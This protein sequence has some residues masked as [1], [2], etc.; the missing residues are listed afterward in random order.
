MKFKTLLLALS[1]ACLIPAI[2]QAKP[3]GQGPGRKG[4]NPGQMFKKFDTDKSG[5][6]SKTEAADANRLLKQFDNIDAD[7]DGEITK[8]EFGKHHKA[9]AEK[10][11]GARDEHLKEL[12]A[13]GSGTISFEEAENG[14]AKRMVDN[15]DKLDAD[16]DG[17]ISTEE[18]KAVGDK[19]RDRKKG[20]R[21]ESE[22]A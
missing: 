18:L 15:F 14:D 4:P 11:K 12:D 16:G 9:M 13:D 1:A 7:S 20:K 5:S 21:S 10:K 17:E 3:D 6:I 22:D 19:M 8:Q 2:S